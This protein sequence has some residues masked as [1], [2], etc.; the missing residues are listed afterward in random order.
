MTTGVIIAAIAI[1]VTIVRVRLPRWP[2][3]TVIA[4]AFT[5]DSK[6]DNAGKTMT[7][8]VR[9]SIATGTETTEATAT[10]DATATTDATAAARITS[11]P[12]VKGLCADMT[13]VFVRPQGTIAGTETMVA[14][15]SN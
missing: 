14:G 4:T 2:L 9:I 11:K 5:P 13:R 1:I 8:N 6:M 15:R 12:T 7:R 3:T 10:M